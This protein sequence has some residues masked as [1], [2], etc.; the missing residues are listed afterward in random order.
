MLIGAH[1][2]K[3]RRLHAVL[4]RF[5]PLVDKE[6]WIWNAM[7]GGVHLLNA[8]LHKIGVTAEVDSFHSQLEGLYVVP[9]RTGGNLRDA[10]HPPGDVMHVGQPPIAAP[11]PPRIVRACAALRSIEDLREPYVRGDRQPE[12]GDDRRW[13]DRY[14]E[15]VNEL[16]AEMGVDGGEST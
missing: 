6:M 9:D 1:L 15:C 4:E 16:V 3:F 10:L 11:L 13:R 7:N 2:A 8:A 12:P 14:L 5:D